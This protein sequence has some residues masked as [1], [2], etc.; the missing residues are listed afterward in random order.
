M[1]LVRYIPNKFVDIKY[2]QEVAPNKLGDIL[3]NFA[4]HYPEFYKPIMYKKSSLFVNG[5]NF[6]SEECVDYFVKKDDIIEITHT[7]EGVIPL[8]IGVIAAAVVTY[9]AISHFLDL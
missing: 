8:I 1:A 4:L 7:I 2:E 3:Y 5:K 9:F 6:T